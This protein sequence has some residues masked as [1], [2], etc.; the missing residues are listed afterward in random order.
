MASLIRRI[1]R[2]WITF[3]VFFCFATVGAIG[4]S[5]SP[6]PA[7]TPNS[8]LTAKTSEARTI[9]I[10]AK[11]AA[12]QIKNNFQRGL[13][14]DEIGAAEA[15]TGDLD[16]AVKTAN[17]AY[18]HTMATLT[19]IGEQ[20][21]KV[22]D[23]ARAQSIG[24]KLSHGEASTVFAVIS[25]SQAKKGNIEEAL[26]TT[27]L[28][29]A[30]EVRSG[31]LEEIAQQ[32]A[33]HGDYSAARKTLALAR[34]ADPTEHSIPEDVEMM[35]V[36]LQ[37]SR[38]DTQAARTTIVSMKSVESRSI[39]ML[40]GADEL[41]KRGDN[42]AAAVWLDSAL[43][44][45]PAGTEYDFLRYIALPIQVKLGQKDR[46]MRA[47]GALSGDQ[48]ASGYN[49]VAVIC[50]ETKDVACVNAALQKMKSAASA[51]DEDKDP[52]DFGVKLMILNVS[53]ALTDNGQFDVAERLLMTV[54]QHLDDVS[55]KRG[56]EPEAQLQRVFMLAQQ[57]RF[58]DARSL[59][60]KMQADSVADVQRGTALRLT[61]LFQTRKSGGQSSQPLALA[62]TDA[63]DRAYALL[64][65]AQAVLGIGSMKLPYAAIR[66]H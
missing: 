63:E 36:A 55:S 51:A 45:L 49:S 60:L 43:K 15:N 35:M 24:S 64:G 17:Q 44:A 14:L 13:V 23:L 41:L 3:G 58:D 22:N 9:L 59:A 1:L 50:A 56:I 6:Q 54:E 2:G 19:A 29:Q 5:P 33:A 32:Q 12:L 20:L 28:I 48:R 37:L 31:A 30:P 39:A 53:A 65:I 66:I 21:G 57:D 26:R 34:T 27:V 61:F 38:G 16:A 11:A 42:A 10:Q 4:Q 47:A 52:S 25:E 40:S 18:P 62:L 46:A 8:V 7:A